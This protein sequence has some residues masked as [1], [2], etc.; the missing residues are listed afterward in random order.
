MRLFRVRYRV[1]AIEPKRIDVG[2]IED[3]VWKTTSSNTTVNHLVATVAHGMQPERNV[4]RRGAICRDASPV[5]GN[6]P[7]LFF[8]VDKRAS[9]GL[10]A[11]QRTRYLVAPTRKLATDQEPALA[12]EY[13]R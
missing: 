3:D 11:Q 12:P 10:Q 2:F 5:V 9:A 8:A 4:T 13:E 6:A 1:H 7:L